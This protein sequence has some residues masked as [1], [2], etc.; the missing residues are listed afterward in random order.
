MHHRKAAWTGENLGQAVPFPKGNLMRN[1]VLTPLR[2]ALLSALGAALAGSCG[3]SVSG[4][5]GGSG[6]GSP[7]SSSGSGGEVCAG[8]QPIT[9]SDGRDTGFARCP[10]GTIHRREAL[11]C[12]PVIEARACDA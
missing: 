12:S 6:A 1:V 7:T 10:D 4:D 11:A 2:T 5:S 3:G 9:G 8:A